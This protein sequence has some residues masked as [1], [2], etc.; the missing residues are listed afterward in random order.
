MPVTSTPQLFATVHLGLGH[1]KEAFKFLERAYEQRAIEV[2]GFSGPL[3]DML[4]DDPRY[5]DLI[6]RMGLADA[7]FPKRRAG[8][9][10]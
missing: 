4:H 1:D 2:L 8:L 9:M 7:F 3:F 5:R 6:G 10:P